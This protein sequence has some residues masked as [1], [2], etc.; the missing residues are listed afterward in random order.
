[1]AATASSSYSPDLSKPSQSYY[2]GQRYTYHKSSLSDP[3]SSTGGNG[4]PMSLPPLLPSDLS[5]EISP[6]SST[7]SSSI[8]TPDINDSNRDQAT[9]LSTPKMASDHSILSSMSRQPTPK[10]I[11]PFEGSTSTSTSSASY[12]SSSMGRFPLLPPHNPLRSKMYS[13]PEYT[14]SLHTSPMKSPA[15]TPKG[16]PI[17]RG[18]SGSS[19]FAYDASTKSH[20]ITNPYGTGN[21]SYSTTLSY[22][23][24][25]PRRLRPVLLI[26]VCVFTFGLVLLNRAMS[27]AT[28][29]DH[30]IN[31]RDLAFSRRYVD[32]SSGH[33]QVNDQYPLIANVIDDAR[34][35]EA[36]IQTTTAAGK[37]LEFKNTE[38]EFA[39][40]IS[41]ITSTTA[42]ALPSIDPSKPL[43]PHKVLDFDPTHSNAKEDLILL[44]QEI[45]TMYP[46]ILIGK[47]RDPYHRE[48]KRILSEYKI[49]PSPLIIDVDQRRDSEI[50]I[51]LF[52]RLLDLGDKDELPQ[53]V[54]QGKSLGSYHDIL[55]LRDQGKLIEMFEENEHISISQLK[56]KKKGLK[57]KERIENE[58]ILKPAPIVPY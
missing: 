41:F 36:A 21:P 35:A 30:L 52:S 14:A 23:L 50:I 47:M 10:L 54:L 28:H 40:L 29:M 15:H 45:N 2:G 57:E 19:Y 48:I 5:E 27:Q 18:R 53:L 58:R 51:P 1:M 38:E 7:S 11:L 17:E 16:H 25:I 20:P 34:Q 39:A 56:K 43:D 24:K 22:L 12:S 4:S 55:N 32:Q 13:I 9:I 46:I 37:A 26:G 6:S 3:S 44:Q 33:A 31:Q 49:T 42:N 8:L